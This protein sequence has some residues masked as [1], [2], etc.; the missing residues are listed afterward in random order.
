MGTYFSFSDYVMYL[1]GHLSSFLS[2]ILCATTVACITML[3]LDIDT[4]RRLVFSRVFLKCA[5]YS[6]SQN[7]NRHQQTIL[8]ASIFSYLHQLPTN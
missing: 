1:R 7:K 3:C 2:S 6:V 5:G 8:I 4:S